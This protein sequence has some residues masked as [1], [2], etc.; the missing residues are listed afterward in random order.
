MELK[1]QTLIIKGALGTLNQFIKA[2]NASRWSSNAMKQDL[3]QLVFIECKQQRLISFNRPIRM[4]YE[5]YVRFHTQDPD[6][7]QFQKKFIHDGLKLA[8]VIPDDN[9]KWIKG[10]DTEEFYPGVK[11]EDIK[12]IVTMYEI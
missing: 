6:N 11:K 9:L 2:S 3:T 8:K 10:F 7:I 4:K 5:W 1:K 12:V